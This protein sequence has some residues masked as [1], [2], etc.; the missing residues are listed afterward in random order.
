MGTGQQTGQLTRKAAV[1]LAVSIT[2]VVF[3]TKFYNQDFQ[4]AIMIGRKYVRT[5]SVLSNLTR[6]NVT[7]N[8]GFVITEESINALCDTLS[9]DF[10]SEITSGEYSKLVNAT[11]GQRQGTVIVTIQTFTR[12]NKKKTVGGDLLIIWAVQKHGGLGRVAGHVVDEGN[13]QYT[14]ILRVPWSGPTIILV[15]VGTAIE[16]AC[17]RLKAMKKYGNSV[18]SLHKGWGIR[19]VFTAGSNEVSTPCGANSY[20]YG[21]ANVCNFTELN[22]NL[23][24]FCGHPQICDCSNIFSFATGP[25]DASLVN[26]NEKVII[27]SV[28]PL[29]KGYEIEAD[30]NKPRPRVQCKDR[31][32]LDSWLETTNAT[33]G[34]WQD[35]HWQFMNCYTNINH[36]YDS[37]RK[38]LFNKTLVFL[39]DSTVRQYVEFILHKIMDIPVKSLKDARGPERT[40]H[41]REWFEKH[42]IRLTY[43]KHAMPFHNPDFPP[44]NITS[45]GTELNTLAKSSISDS[46]LIVM[47]NYHVHY[48]AYPIF[49]FRDRIRH[50]VKAL[51]EFLKL[52]PRS[53]I[54]LKSPHLCHLDTRWYDGT[55]SMIYKDIMLEEFGEL[56]KSVI[57]LDVWSISLAHNNQDLHPEGDALQSQIQQF[58]SYIC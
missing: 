1:F 45:Y 28:Y 43:L 51:R 6:L 42:G 52:K 32:A 8:K 36:V 3:V 31:P 39:G 41:S 19:G 5:K 18:F 7:V 48:Q 53:K 47:I 11:P 44:K 13:G 30:G 35:N 17:L 33:S 16:N 10:L 22:D 56:K 26:P 15:K 4:H 38:C 25:F 54:L 34:F 27:P 50:L 49:V 21:F 37:Y 58:M 2:T 14:G 29:R 23:S 46:E 55:I 24:W 9:P 12:S 40:Y 57:Y 20:I